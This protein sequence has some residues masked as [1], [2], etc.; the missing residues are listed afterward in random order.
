VDFIDARS[1]FVYFA[2]LVLFDGLPNR[3]VVV[4][5]RIHTYRILQRQLSDTSTDQL[6]KR[7]AEHNLNHRNSAVDSITPNLHC[8]PIL[9]GLNPSFPMAT[10]GF[11]GCYA[12]M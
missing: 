11:A 5:V 2:N 9:I 6:A 7:F 4:A 3:K 12:T 10:L 1:A 8:D